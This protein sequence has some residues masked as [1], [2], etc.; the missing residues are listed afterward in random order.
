MDKWVLHVIL[1]LFIWMVLVFLSKKRLWANLAVLCVIVGLN[2]IIDFVEAIESHKI[3]TVHG[4]AE[5]IVLSV[6]IPL[7]LTNIL[8]GLDYKE[9]S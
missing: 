7:C 2:E 9:T 8:L 4:L 1:G 6:A 3:I 5:V